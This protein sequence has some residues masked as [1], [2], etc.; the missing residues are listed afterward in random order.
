[1]DLSPAHTALREA[2]EEI[3]LDRNKVEVVCTLP[4]Q[5][6]T[7]SGLTAVNLV[8][9]LLKCSPEELNL[10]PNP[11]EVDCIYWVPLELFTTAQSPHIPGKK[12]QWYEYVLEHK[13]PRS[14]VTHRIWGFTAFMCVLMAC[15]AHNQPFDSSTRPPPML[16]SRLE[17]KGN[18][19]IATCTTI[20]LTQTQV[21]MITSSKL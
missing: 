9:A 17:R 14:G 20:A 1:M 2:E 8:V 12:L 16:I 4:P 5:V 15:I 11:L 3:G 13:E 6:T 19:M 10:S 21:A 7:L 18:T